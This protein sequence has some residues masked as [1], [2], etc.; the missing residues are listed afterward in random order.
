MNTQNLGY[1]PSDKA[2]T[3][4][5]KVKSGRKG[6]ERSVGAGYRAQSAEHRL[7][8]IEDRAESTRHR[9]QSAEYRLDHRDCRAW[10]GS[11]ER[12]QDRA[13]RGEYRRQIIHSTGGGRTEGVN[14]G[15]RAQCVRR[16][17]STAH[18]L[19]RRECRVYSTQNSE[20]RMVHIQT[21][22]RLLLV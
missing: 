9:A 5:P 7:Q 2:D 12:V 22:T 18:K 16:V 21:L 11:T 6:S 15:Y 4:Y 19:L 10:G 3:D 20:A 1:I 17:C 13:R 14:T 8:A